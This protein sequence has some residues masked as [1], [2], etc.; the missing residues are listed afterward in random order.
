MPIGTMN[1][2]IRSGPRRALVVNPSTSVPTPPSPVPRMTPVRSASS[3]S[4]RS[5]RPA[6][7]SASAAATSPNWAY[8]SVRRISL[9]S[10]RLPASKPRTSP[11]IR[12]VRR[13][14]SNASMVRIPDRPATRPAQVV[15]T[16][17]PSAVIMPIPVTT[18]R[19]RSGT[20]GPPSLRF[21][22][23]VIEPICR[24][25]RWPRGRHRREVH[26]RRW[27]WPRR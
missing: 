4:K 1:G 20:S 25:A 9:R 19:R 10:R 14:G 13:D 3:P 7:R 21:A 27:H 26:G 6:W 5:G 15:G 8:R 16:S 17:L 23:S 22:A 12:D 11:A 24:Y 2:L 18:T